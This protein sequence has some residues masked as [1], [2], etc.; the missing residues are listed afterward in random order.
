MLAVGSDS[1]FAKLC[2]ILGRSGLA[3]DERYATNALRVR[4]RDALIPVLRQEL[5][6]W[7]RDELLARLADSGVPAGPINTI[8]DVFADPQVRARG[9]RVD[10]DRPDIAREF[11]IEL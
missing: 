10:F 9:M 6:P 11:G 7:K 1:Q 5:R 4:N 3:T 2:S 8:A